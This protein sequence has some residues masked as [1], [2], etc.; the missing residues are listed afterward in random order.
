VI[1]FPYAQKLLSIIDDW[2]FLFYRKKHNSLLVQHYP[3]SNRHSVLPLNL[4]YTLI[5]LLH[6]F[7]ATLTYTETNHHPNSK[8][9]VHFS[10]LRSLQITR[11]S[12]TPCVTFRNMVI[13]CGEE[14]FAGGPLLV[15]C[16]RLL[17]QYIHSYPAYLVDVSPIRHPRRRHVDKDP[18]NMKM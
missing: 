1:L 14:L 13:L 12:P 3:G 4:T 15:G 8:S 18:L 2:R 10:M 17:S 6:W 7:L 11:P 9:H 16:A 5:V